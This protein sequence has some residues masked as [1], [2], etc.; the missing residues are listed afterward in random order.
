M[1]RCHRASFLSFVAGLCG[2]AAVSAA[3]EPE[4]QRFRDWKLYKTNGQCTLITQIVSRRSETVVV[5][6]ILRQRSD[7]QPGASI[8]MR[9]PNG[10][11][12]AD[13]IAYVH[14]EH[15]NVAIGLRWHSCASEKCLA[16]GELTDAGLNKLK[17]GRYIVVGFRPLKGASMLNVDVPLFGVTRGWAELE[18]CGKS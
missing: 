12:I 10:A 3:A 16:V 11:S 9:V 4:E 8:G 5:D 14:P 18:R 7:G 6:V 17:R 2:F 13:D 1:R 15:P